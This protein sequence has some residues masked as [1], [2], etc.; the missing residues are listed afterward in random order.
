MAILPPPP[1]A[2][3][4]RSIPQLEPS[5]MA[6][7]QLIFDKD[8]LHDDGKDWICWVRHRLATSSASDWR[9]GSRRGESK[10]L[11]MGCLLWKLRFSEP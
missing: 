3:R 7:D 2:V 10:R 4:E 6:T 5:S 8:F 1:A 11:S 9:N